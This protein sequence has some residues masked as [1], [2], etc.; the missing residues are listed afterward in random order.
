M[1]GLTAAAGNPAGQFAVPLDV[2]KV[3]AVARTQEVQAAALYV[4][5]SDPAGLAARAAALVPD[6][7]AFVG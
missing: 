1:E 2:L 7:W 6:E 3:A 4:H 5:T